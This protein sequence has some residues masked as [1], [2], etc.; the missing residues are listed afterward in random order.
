[1]HGVALIELLFLGEI[2]FG[3][4]TDQYYVFGEHQGFV[5][6]QFNG[7]SSR[8]AIGPAVTTLWHRRA[9]AQRSVS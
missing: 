1:M 3:L 6:G 5:R 9:R 7:R 4:V 8:S 2:G